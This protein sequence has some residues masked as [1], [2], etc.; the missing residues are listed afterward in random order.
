MANPEPKTDHLIPYQFRPGESGNPRGRPKG[1]SLTA[2][3]HEVLDST[4]LCGAEV[5]GG[6]TV[7]RALVEAMLAHAIRRGDPAL[8]REA[9]ARVDGPIV[10]PT[11]GDDL[12][13]LSDAELLA[14]VAGALGRDGS[15]GPQA[16]GPPDPDD[17][18]GVT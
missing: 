3:L 1:L 18:P 10:T 16:A 2:I 17:G 8:I 12:S 11:H 15:S 6:R 5:P 9:I 14:Q 13:R 7:A 4:E